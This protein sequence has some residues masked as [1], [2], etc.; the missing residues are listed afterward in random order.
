MD[1]GVEDLV[2]DKTKVNPFLGEDMLQKE[3]YEC[4]QIN[5]MYLQIW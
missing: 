4:Q 5:K 3:R 1:L 2:A